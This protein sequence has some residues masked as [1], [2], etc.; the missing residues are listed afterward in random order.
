VHATYV[1]GFGAAMPVASNA[2]E[3]DRQRNRRVEAWLEAPR[4]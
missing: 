3:A 4:H 2:T 1:E